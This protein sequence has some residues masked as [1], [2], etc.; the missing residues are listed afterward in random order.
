MR[1]PTAVAPMLIPAS[2][3]LACATAPSEPAVPA[4]PQA[5]ER[6]LASAYD[7]DALSIKLGGRPV[8]CQPSP[9][10]ED[11]CEWHLSERMNAWQEFAEILDTRAT[12]AVICRLPVDGSVRAAGSCSAWPRQSNRRQLLPRGKPDTPSEVALCEASESA[13][14]QWLDD[15]ATVAEMTWLLGAVP[16]QCDPGDASSARF[17]CV[18][19]LRKGHFG[20]GTVAA[21]IGAWY[22]DPVSLRCEFPNDGGPRSTPSCIAWKE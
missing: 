22:R 7:R 6:A 3:A 2:I 10:S 16:T 13:T 1:A 8:Q 9:P 11:L 14:R 19:Q 4:D 20:H 12:I 5:V 21:S 17:I 15:A 18:W